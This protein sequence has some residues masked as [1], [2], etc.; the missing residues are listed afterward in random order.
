ME[1]KRATN[2]VR[3]ITFKLSAKCPISRQNKNQPFKVSLTI[4]K[5]L[6]SLNYR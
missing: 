5:Q 4:V 1:D 2:R 6:P 3:I